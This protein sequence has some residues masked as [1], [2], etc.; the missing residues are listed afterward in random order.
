VDVYIEDGQ[1]LAFTAHQADVNRPFG[2]G[3][4]MGNFS[5]EA[6]LISCHASHTRP[7]RVG[8]EPASWRVQLANVPLTTGDQAPCLRVECR[9]AEESWCV[10]VSVRD[11]E[12][13]LDHP[14]IRR[15]L[16]PSWPGPRPV[17]WPPDVPPG[18]AGKHG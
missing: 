5:P 16:G 15:I 14:V 6:T 8:G 13:L 17:R 10:A 11:A 3:Y 7:L 12:I 1:W 4:A 9:A 2:V 18:Q